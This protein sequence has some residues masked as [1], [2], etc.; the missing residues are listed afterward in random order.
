MLWERV[1]IVLIKVAHHGIWM[2][3]A[4]PRVHFNGRGDLGEKGGAGGSVSRGGGREEVDSTHGHT[5]CSC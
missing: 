1:R 2:L 4:R 5:L 3:T